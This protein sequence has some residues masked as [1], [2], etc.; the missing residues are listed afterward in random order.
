MKVDLK[1][2]A[3]SRILTMACCPKVFESQCGIAYRSA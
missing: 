1:I 2:S 3:A